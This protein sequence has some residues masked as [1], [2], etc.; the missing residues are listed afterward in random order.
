MC[1]EGQR[2]PQDYAQ[3]VVWFRKAADQGDPLAQGALGYMYS[4]GEGVPQD[5]AEAVGW[6]RKG[7]DQGYAKAQYDLGN[8]YYEGKGV[9]QDYSEAVRWYR[10]AA[11]QGYAR[12]QDGL[13]YMYSHG[14]GVPE[15]PAEAARWYRKAAKQG[16]EYGKRALSSMKISFTAQSEIELLVAFLGNIVFLT[17]WGDRRNRE[18]RGIVLAGLLGLSWVGLDVYGHFRF[19]ILQA[20]SA[21]NAFYFGKSL[22]GGVSAAILISLVWPH[23]AKTALRICG[24]LFIGFNIYAVAHY[25]LRHLAPALRA[26]CSTNGLLIGNA[27]PLAIFLW[28]DRAKAAEGG[29]SN[30]GAPPGGSRTEPLQL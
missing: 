5:Y 11:D 30:N 24:I 14:K 20:L 15:D 27:I 19:G 4:K 16:D 18:Q 29:G 9:P 2:V 6:Y 25:D 3:A 13:G 28:L 7:A 12:A 22:V 1:Q 10:R 23:W 21:V 8:S 17:R 26:F